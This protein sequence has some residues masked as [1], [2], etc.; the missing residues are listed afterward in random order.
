MAETNS[1]GQTVLVVED[2]DDNRR[3]L[4]MLLERCGYSVL[5]ALNGEEAVEMAQRE[6]PDLILM[7]I[8]LPLLDGFVATQFIRQQE[9]LRHTPIVALTAYGNNQSRDVALAAGCDDYLEKPVNF[10]QVEKLLKHY[11]PGVNSPLV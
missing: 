1:P 2:Y 9:E 6:H 8:N 4:R 7:D 3:M 11:L 5:E 10:A